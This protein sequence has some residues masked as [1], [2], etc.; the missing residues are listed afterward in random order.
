MDKQE[1]LKIFTDNDNFDWYE[2]KYKE[3]EEEYNLINVEPS[4]IN[5]IGPIKTVSSYGGEGG[6]DEYYVVIY[7]INYDLYI[8]NDG[9]YTSYEGGYFDDEPYFVKPVE[10]TIIFYEKDI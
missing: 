2:A 4:I 1:I 7:L 3:G 6:G 9:W 10:K 5:K 8:R